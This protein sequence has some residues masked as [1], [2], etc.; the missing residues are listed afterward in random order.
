[1]EEIARVAGVSKGTLYN[2]YESK[3]DLLIATILALYQDFVTPP[4][5]VYDESVEP[6]ERL[7]ALIES[8]ALGFDAI[9]ERMPLAHQAWSVILGVASGREKLLGALRETLGG[10]SQ[11][12]QQIL[13]VGVESG[14][15]QPD[16]D[17]PMVAT[18]WLAIYD[19]L[20]YRAAF[21]TGSGNQD[22][23][24]ETVRRSLGWLLERTLIDS[25]ESHEMDMRTSTKEKDATPES[26]R[27]R[28]GRGR[29]T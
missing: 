16:L 15:L 19:G 9:A 26:T 11:D 8:F 4:P 23:C 24:A 22:Y 3:E 28:V 13:Q 29:S 14:S 27:A 10:Y 1:M 5:S 25:E 20:L 2:Y 12:L 7:E 21:E 6:R 18:L 17:V